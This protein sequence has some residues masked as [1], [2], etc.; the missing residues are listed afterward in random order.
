MSEE[1]LTNL[2]GHQVY[3]ISAEA[4]PASFITRF[5]KVKVNVVSFIDKEVY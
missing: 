1:G 4:R 3:S 2:D 5:Y